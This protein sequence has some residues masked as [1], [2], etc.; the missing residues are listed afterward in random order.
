MVQQGLGMARVTVRADGMEGDFCAEMPG[1]KA[2]L[3]P[4]G[5]ESETEGRQPRRPCAVPTVQ[6][7]RSQCC[8]KGVSHL[9]SWDNMSLRFCHRLMPFPTFSTN[10]GSS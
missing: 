2:S 3:F 6:V 4:P 5:S 7:L 1:E 8:S 9:P 10:S